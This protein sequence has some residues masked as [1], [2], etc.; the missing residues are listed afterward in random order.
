MIGERPTAGSRGA[1]DWEVLATRL[2]RFRLSHGDAVTPDDP[3]G[4]HPDRI[5]GSRRSDYERERH[6][7]AAEI[8]MYRQ[9]R[10]LPQ[11]AVGHALVMEALVRGNEHRQVDGVALEVGQ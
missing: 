5:P 9:A 10:Q 4:P 11:D 8:D 7:L 3:L 2:E 1:D 6:E